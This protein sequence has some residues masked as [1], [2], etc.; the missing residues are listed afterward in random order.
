MISMVPFYEHFMT[1][2]EIFP[3]DSNGIRLHSLNANVPMLFFLWRH[4]A[5]ETH[6]A[7]RDKTDKTHGEF[8]LIFSN[9]VFS[10]NNLSPW[11]NKDTC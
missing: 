7:P 4:S 2:Q 8:V 1:C 3:I 6:R 5:N 11:K 10:T 9:Q